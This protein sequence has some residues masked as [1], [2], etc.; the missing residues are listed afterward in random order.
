MRIVFTGGGSGGHFYP[1]IAVAEEILNYSKEQKLLDIQMYYM[2]TDPYSDGILFDNNIKFRKVWAGKWRRYFSILNFC[3]LFKTAVGI[4][5]AIWTLFQIYPDAVFGKGGFASFPTLMAARILRIPV[6]IQESDTVPGR[7]NKWAGKFARRVAI[8][9]PEAEKYFPKG[10]TAYTGNPV[11]LELLNLPSKKEG[12]EF[13]KLDASLPTILVLG[14]SQG[15]Q[16]IND[17]IIDALP[18]IVK[19]Y[20]VIHQT[21]KINVESVNETVD[22]VLLNN[23]NRGRYKMLPY[24]D[25]LSMRMA[26]SAADLVISRAGS[27]AISEIAIWNLLSIIVPI[28]QEVS[29][30]Q[31]KNAFAYARAGAGVV[32][33]EENL[34]PNLLISEI[35]RILSDKE[36][37]KK[38]KN[39]ARNFARPDAARKIAEGIIAIALKHEE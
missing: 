25:T 17:A 30:D 21:G 5:R 33:E 11:R 7:V 6:L 14:G 13:H 28:S 3:D 20:Q 16:I 36:L 31:R 4:I 9:Y 24:L 39:G 15:A 38:M 18:E 32:I 10:K 12:L 2:S 23:P 35:N 29:H 26:A 19:S 37:Q 34:T 22:V 27:G 8:A 1:I